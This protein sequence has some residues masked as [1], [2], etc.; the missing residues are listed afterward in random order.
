MLATVAALLF[1][2]CEPPPEEQQE[3]E[4]S[5]AALTWQG[6][7]IERDDNGS[8]QTAYYMYTVDVPPPSDVCGPDSDYIV[9][10]NR[11][12]AY[13][14]RSKLRMDGVTLAAQC[15]LT[16]NP[17]GLSARVYDDNHVWVCAGSVRETLCGG[18][19]AIFG[20]LQLWQAP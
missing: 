3:I 14:N 6:E 10:Y 13:A 12:G 1:A 19:D 16:L 20:G 18:P 2:G 5:T 9:H 15:F 8:Q 7:K 4:M 17:S 11:T